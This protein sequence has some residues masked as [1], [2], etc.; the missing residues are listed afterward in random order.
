MAKLSDNQVAA[1][2]VLKDLLSQTGAEGATASRWKAHADGKVVVT[3]KSLVNAGAVREIKIA[4][5][6]NGTLTIA[7]APL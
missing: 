2:A 3:A 1:V 6:T 4:H 7:Y 5:L